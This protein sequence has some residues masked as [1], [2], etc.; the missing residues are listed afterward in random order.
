MATPTWNLT[1]QDCDAF[2]GGWTAN[3]DGGL[4]ALATEDSR[5]VYKYTAD[6]DGAPYAVKTDLT[7]WTQCTAEI[8][9]KIDATPVS[10]HG[11]LTLYLRDNSKYGYSMG[12][13]SLSSVTYPY[14]RCCGGDTILRHWI[15]VT[16]SDWHTGRIVVNSSHN[17]WFWLD[18]QFICSLAYSGSVH[19]NY[20]NNTIGVLAGTVP[21]GTKISYVDHIRMSSSKSEADDPGIFEVEGV[22]AAVNTRVASLGSGGTGMPDSPNN[23]SDKIRYHLER[24]IAGGVP[25]T[26][27]LVATTDTYA[28]EARVYDGSSTKSMQRVPVAADL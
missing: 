23:P 16:S 12:F 2:D 20:T 24:N 18:N 22:T 14:I 19:T 21:S 5:T 10:E 1:D 8:A 7:A 27:P 9:F 6:V 25:Y 28:S 3:N 17:A 26:I 15:D 13:W 4:I 11:S